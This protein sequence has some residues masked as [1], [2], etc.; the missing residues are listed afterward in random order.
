MTRDAD[1]YQNRE[2]YPRW[3][4]ST[5]GGAAFETRR[6]GF[7]RGLKQ[8]QKPVTFIVGNEDLNTENALWPLLVEKIPGPTLVRVPAAGHMPWVDQPATLQIAMCN[9]L[10]HTP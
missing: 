5:G 1:V 7:L 4:A 6:A 3:V 10:A 9:A 8:L 2:V